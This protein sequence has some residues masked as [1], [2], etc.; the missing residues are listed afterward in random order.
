MHV[1][2]KA[3]RFVAALTIVAAMGFWSGCRAVSPSGGVAGGPD[4]PRPLSEDREAFAEALALY[5]Q[6][7]IHQVHGEFDPAISNYLR[8]IELDPGQDELY[9]RV[10][11]GHLRMDR[12]DEAIK[13][14]ESLCERQPR[15]ARPQ[16]WLGFVC[17]AAG[18]IPRAETAYKKA[19]RIAPANEAAYLELAAVYI[20][21]GQDDEAV[22]LLEEGILRAEQPGDLLRM[23]GDL[24]IRK[25]AE[26]AAENTEQTNRRAAIKTLERIINEEPDDVALLLQLGD[27]YI[28]EEDVPRAI[29]YFQRIEE[30]EPDNLHVKKKLALSFAAT[31]N[32]ERAVETLEKITREQPSNAQVY[33]YLG[34]LYEK[35]GDMER[36]RLN[37]SLA[38]KAPTTD[39]SA[40]LRLALLDM[41]TE[42]QTAIDILMDGLVKHPDDLRLI[43]TAAYA[44]MNQKDYANARKYFKTADDLMRENDQQAMTPGFHFYFAITAQHAGDF[45]EAEALLERTFDQDP[46]FLDAYVHYIFQQEGNTVLQEAIQMLENIQPGRPEKQQVFVYIG[47][48]NSFLKQ[49]EE[50][51]EA[52]R[53]AETIAGAADEPV[54]FEQS[55]YFWYAAANERVG[56]YEESETLFRKVIEMNPEH[57]EAYNYLAYMWAEQDINLDEALLFIEKALALEPESGAFLDTYGWVLY[58]QGDYGQAAVQIEHA[59]RIL[60]EDPTI[61]EHMGDVLFK[62]NRPG[63][64]VEYWRK[65]LKAD[66]EKQSLKDKLQEQGI[67]VEALLEEFELQPPEEDPEPPA[68][69]LDTPEP[70]ARKM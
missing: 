46:H 67:D 44:Y 22:S 2:A 16:L 35:M 27:L 13:V 52:F 60:P 34:E 15:E 37:F 40:F 25:A 41:D 64:A 55:F 10:A 62:L 29:E 47:L 36:A 12:P 18:D 39:A 4:R 42:P 30:L 45:P 50:A 8:A 26:S 51:V 59:S 1:S 63:E 65:A 61:A 9:M 14:I 31:G 70:S 58:M 33:Y 32:Q 56:A 49:Y 48:L 17:R 21:L 20:R 66:P 28:M 6:G 69:E 54:P 5:S 7:L 68:E 24:Y 3:G 53:Q 23:L 19:I 57:A 43:E 11:M 38:T